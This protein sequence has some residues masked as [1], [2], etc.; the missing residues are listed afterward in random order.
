M[1]STDRRYD[2]AIYWARPVNDG[3]PVAGPITVSPELIKVRWQDERGIF[4][5]LQGRE[6]DAESVIYSGKALEIGGFL[7]RASKLNVANVQDYPPLVPFELKE[8]LE[9]YKFDNNLDGVNNNDLSIISGAL[10]F[11]TGIAGQAVSSNGGIGY[12]IESDSNIILAG[13]TEL[14]IAFWIQMDAPF[15]VADIATIKI[16]NNMRIFVHT[17]TLNRIDWEDSGDTKSTSLIL[18]D[19]F[20]SDFIH[21]AGTWKKG[22]IQ[23]IYLNGI[24]QNTFNSGGIYD[25]VLVDD[26]LQVINLLTAG[27][28]DDILIDELRLYNSLLDDK[29][30]QILAA[31]HPSQYPNAFEIRNNSHST[32]LRKTRNIYKS[33]LSK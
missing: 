28:T 2:D 22:E 31:V 29:Q 10:G 15:G 1:A 14:T 5:D 16:L 23:D 3:Y 20:A 27:S 6:F 17:G 11:D 7:L 4:L 18:D 33:W 12:V 25:S 9:Y 30:I 21:I 32:N 26:K 13:A 19:G 8:Y 24:K